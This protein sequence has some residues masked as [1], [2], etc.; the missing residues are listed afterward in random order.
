MKRGFTEMRNRNLNPRWEVSGYALLGAFVGFILLSTGIE[1]ALV[2]QGE[3]W[4]V[5]RVFTVMSSSPL[6]W[7]VALSV[8]AFGGG[9]GWLGVK[10]AQ[11]RLLTASLQ[12]VLAEK[13]AQEAIGKTQETE[14]EV[15]Q[16]RVFEALKRQV[17]YFEALFAASP[18]AVVIL[19]EARKVMACNSAFENLFG[20][21]EKEMVGGCLDDFVTGE[22]ERS[23]A[24]RLTQTVFGGRPVHEFRR[25]RGKD[26]RTVEVELLG[27]PVFIEEKMMG[28]LVLYHD[29]TELLVARQEAEEAA[30]VKSAFLSNMSHE[31]RTPMNGV[32]G[33]LQLLTHTAL[34]SEQRDYLETAQVSAETLMALLNDMLDFSQVEIGQLALE[35][36]NFDLRALIKDVIASFTKRANEKALELV[37]L[38]HYDV[39]ERMSGD[40]ARLKQIL[41]NLIGNA[42]KFTPVGEVIL[43]VALAQMADDTV[44]LRFTVHDTGIGIPAA[45]QATIFERFSQGDSSYTRQYGGSGLGL[46]LTQKLVH[47]MRG[48]IGVESEV[49]IGSTFWFTAMF[50]RLPEDETLRLDVS[51]NVAQTRVLLVAEDASHRGILTKM[52]RQIGCEVETLTNQQ[53]VIAHLVEA[54]TQGR[55]F[56]VL[57]LDMQT[58]SDQ[59]D[60]TF[61]A[62]QTN[63]FVGDIATLVLTPFGQRK[64]VARLRE[65]GLAGVLVKPVSQ[66]QLYDSLLSVLEKKEPLSKEEKSVDTLHAFPV[67]MSSD[68]RVLLVE[69][70]QV[71]QKLAVAL[72]MKFGYPA[73]T[74][75]NGA[76]A[77]EAFRARPYNLI[78]MDL[79]MPVMDGYEATVQIRNLETSDQHVPILALTA[80]VLKG[81]RERCLAAGMDDYIPKPI[82]VEEFQEKL[83]RWL[84]VPSPPL[85]PP[86]QPARLMPIDETLPFDVQMALPRFAN[87]QKLFYDL[88]REFFKQVEAKLP[89][90]IAAYEKQDAQA[91]F[92]LGHYLKGMAGN[93]S[94]K[95]MVKL[96]LALETAGKEGNLAE[97]PK[98]IEGIRAEYDRIQDFY[99][100]L[101]IQ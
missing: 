26:G 37:F 84:K 45:R 71:N 63:L 54:K 24:E 4:S 77:V 14:K 39:P 92:Q 89:E 78:L 36:A 64:N 32:M 68:L 75:E 95:R 30:H 28:I 82:R 98:L 60:A 101:V 52:L 46:A 79:Q 13:V 33:M 91:L 15:A 1:L 19:D 11:Q 90:V 18:V 34:N 73:D 22:R 31:I 16:Q 58:S 74:V 97:V 27:V 43:R 96:T 29:L 69:D 62:I 35:V 10:Q 85:A 3:T 50:G 23:E 17:Q 42:I 100:Q 94:T 5:A 57:L 9:A 47:L 2:W 87:N 25:R 99:D 8:I 65:Q 83:H 70:N 38:I 49:Q 51:A 44:T 80:S 6:Y 59:L 66:Q 76:Q 67:Q 88:L 81:D 61:Q 21:K 93:F 53:E 12:Q 20:Y 55:A 86:P 7:L 40:P 41:E 72:L 48:E 56:Q